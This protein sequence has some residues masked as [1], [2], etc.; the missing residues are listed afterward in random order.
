MRINFKNQEF[1]MNWKEIAG[2]VITIYLLAT[3]NITILIEF[4]KSFLK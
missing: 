3:G 2:F 4:I 1:E